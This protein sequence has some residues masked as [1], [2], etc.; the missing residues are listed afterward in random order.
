MTTH[1]SRHEIEL[2]DTW[3][4]GP[5][6]LH[7]GFLLELLAAHA[8]TEAHPHPLSTSAHF[9]SSPKI[10]PAEI[11]VTRLRAGRSTTVTRVALVQEKVC[12]DAVVTAGRLAPSSTVVYQDLAVP[13]LPN[14]EDCV[15]TEVE[16][17]DG[18][19]NGIATNLDILLDPA[20]AG[21]AEGSPTEVGEVRGWLRSAT[22]RENDPLFL[23]TL[24]DGL[25]PIPLAL[26]MKGWVPTVQLTV[27][28]RARPA[29]GWVRAVQRSHLIAD[30]WLD[31]ECLLWD[32]SGAL[33]A[34][35]T[36]LAAYRPG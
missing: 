3:A 15:R 34:Q 25:P 31:E 4:Y 10:G 8:V 7:G 13:D 27:N 14:L 16:W 23:I 17:E 12:L 24:A 19:H 33:V 30:G 32:S 35:A 6:I 5:G 2:D 1:E 28:V 26:G 20:T 22:G 9:L 11:Q 36:Q 21:W 29:P 18:Q